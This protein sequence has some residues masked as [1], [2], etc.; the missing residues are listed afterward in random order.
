MCHFLYIGQ[1]GTTQSNNDM[2]K[3]VET[4]LILP[5]LLIKEGGKDRE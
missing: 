4:P 5:P 3:G 1:E 2:R